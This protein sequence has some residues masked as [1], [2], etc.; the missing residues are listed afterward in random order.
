VQTARDL[1]ENCML[2]QFCIVYSVHRCAP[3]CFLQLLLAGRLCLLFL[4]LKFTETWRY[5]AA[6]GRH[7]H[8][9]K[10]GFTTLQIW[11]D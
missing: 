2:Y 9:K 10:E 5:V 8:D 3:Y 7:G 11:H 4:L 1:L 6:Y